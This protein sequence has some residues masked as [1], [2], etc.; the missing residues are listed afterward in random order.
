MRTVLVMG[1]L[2]AMS[3]A[4]EPPAPADGIELLQDP[5]FRR[6]FTL[7]RPEPGRKV[8][9]GIVAGPETGKPAW[10]VAQWSARHPFDAA[11]AV[12]RGDGD[13]IRLAN[14]G[15]AL[16][17]G[18]ADGVLSLAVRA[19]AEY[20]DR[21]RARGEPW[22]H[23]LVEQPVE[24]LPRLSGLA[25]LHLHL[26][27]RRALA[28]LARA[29]GHDPRIHAAQFQVFLSVQNREKGAPGFG[30]YHWFGIPVYD[31]RH[32]VHQTYA[33][34]DSGT[35]KFIYTAASGHFTRGSTHDD[36]WVT[37]DG[38][39]LPLIREGLATARA[40]GFLK[41]SA[42]ESLFRVAAIN[43][44]WEVP[45]TFDVEMEIRRLALRAT[46]RRDAGP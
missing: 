23:L 2:A 28:G 22:V 31:N 20:G 27:A 10:Q 14:G 9:C 42:D 33:A 16:A 6:G 29:A 40:R 34:P 32:R 4:A 36:G 26:E 30:D 24:S 38:E 18:G 46:P 11:T 39:L 21:P 13:T 41:A 43:M 5:A 12:V 1:L 45:G 19:S 37:F 8:P 3:T 35:G 15:R 44:G 25:S 17:F 7:L